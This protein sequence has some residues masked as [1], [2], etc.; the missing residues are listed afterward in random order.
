M[1]LRG[2]AAVPDAD[3]GL[4]PRESPASSRLLR[5]DAPD[6]MSLPVAIR[7]EVLAEQTPNFFRGSPEP[8][9]R[10]DV[11]FLVLF[12]PDLLGLSVTPPL[13]PVNAAAAPALHGQSARLGAV[14]LV[15]RP[16]FGCGARRV[17]A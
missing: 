5:A 2:H 15:G 3:S 7:S 13:A 12:L 11:P 10:A 1:S 17:R 16:L 14:L 9:P 6:P 4:Q 8:R